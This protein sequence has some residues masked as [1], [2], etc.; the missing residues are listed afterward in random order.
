MGTR[1][2]TSGERSAELSLKARWLDKA[3]LIQLQAQAIRQLHAEHLEVT[4]HEFRTLLETDQ[5]TRI[6]SGM[7]AYRGLVLWIKD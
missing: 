3:T 6:S 5:A 4:R 1:A 7:Y 2:C